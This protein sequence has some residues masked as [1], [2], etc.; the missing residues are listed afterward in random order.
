MSQDLTLIGIAASPG[1]SF[2]RAFVFES[3]AMV[4]T[5]RRIAEGR[6]AAEVKRYLKAVE[7]TNRDLNAAEADV[8]KMLGRQHARLI[9]AHRLILQDPILTKDVPKL[10]ETEGIN[11]EFALSETLS[12]VNVAFEALTDE[13]FRERRHDL[14]DVGRRVLRHLHGNRRKSARQEQI[15]D[16][17]IVIARN[18][19][20][21]DTIHLKERKI[22]G[23]ATE[24]GS[25]LSHVA[26]LAQSLEIP[27]VVGVPD[28]LKHVASGDEIIVDGNEGTVHVRPSVATTKHYRQKESRLK[29]EQEDLLAVTQGPAVTADGFTLAISANLDALEELSLVKKWGARGIGLFRTELVLMQWEKP[30]LFDVARQTE[31][32]RR[33]IEEVAPETAVIRLLDIGADKLLELGSEAGLPV[34]IV[35]GDAE[36]KS[37]ILPM[38]LRGIRLALRYPK[39]LKSQLRAILTASTSGYPRILLPMVSAIEEVREVRWL[40]EEIKEE[41]K[42]EGIAFREDIPL[43]IMVEVPSV[44]IKVEAFLAEVDF[45]SVGT[46][47]LVQY[48]LACDRASAELAYLYQEFHPS[49]LQLLSNVTKAAHATKRWVGICGELAGNPLALPLL[50]GMGFDGISVNPHLVPKIKKQLKTLKLSDCRQVV[51]EALKLSSYEEV[52]ELLK[53]QIPMPAPST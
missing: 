44:A 23:F 11:A 43:G 16:S 18:L 8:L 34:R 21:T 13:F 4:V 50:L 3:E 52:V 6:V 28:M 39:I 14:F 41:L 12:R 22:L 24:L 25:R 9:E 35:S 40:L 42:K 1:I 30:I 47:D 37:E 19:L 29:K 48:V 53:R 26:I 32:Y 38:G 46:N 15:G 31:V 17:T 45:I 27:A 49:I 36:S 51:D 33:A 2:G 10:I 20:P 5:K 7:R